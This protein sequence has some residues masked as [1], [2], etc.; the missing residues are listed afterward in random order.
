MKSN[1]KARAAT[2]IVDARTKKTY[3]SNKKKKRKDT[4][5]T[6]SSD[7]K[8]I[9]Q[10]NTQVVWTDQPN[11]KYK[12]TKYDWLFIPLSW[13]IVIGAIFWMVALTDNI[14]LYILAFILLL[15]G[16]Y[17]LLLRTHF[18]KFKRRKLTYEV[19]ETDIN[20]IYTTRKDVEVR[21]LSLEAVRY[22]AYSVRKNGVGT[23][24]FNFPN[25]YLD[26]F[27]LVFANSGLGK[28][29][30]HIFVF[31]EIDDA[32]EFLEKY[33]KPNVNPNAIYEQI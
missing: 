27:K 1:F 33:I 21:Q 9:E 22:V 30:D 28:F 12:R 31:F 8:R 19:T 32:E 5:V 24:Y 15:F 4:E 7:S 16:L 29:D 20:I 2:K 6:S 26:I 11:T 17:C 25:N 18:K 23:I 10:Y 14:L 3:V 13:F